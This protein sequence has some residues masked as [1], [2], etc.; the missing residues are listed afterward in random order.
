MSATFHEPLVP[1]IV[2]VPTRWPIRGWPLVAL[3]TWAA[4]LL[5]LVG[6]QSQKGANWIACPFR[7]LTQLPCPTCGATRATLAMLDG[8]FAG[9][10]R[11]N[12]L[13]TVALM[14]TTFWLVLRIGFRRTIVLPLPPRM[15]L[16]LWVGIILA[17]CGN[18]L[19]VLRTLE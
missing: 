8:D 4:L 2:T 17:A 1:R 10:L 14:L 11:L 3:I 7:S 12:P 16:V 5:M 15:R 19:Y 18:W 9:A 6:A 13:V